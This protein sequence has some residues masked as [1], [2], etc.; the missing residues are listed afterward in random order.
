MPVYMLDW[1]S[2]SW[3]NTRSVHSRTAG[4]AADRI[5]TAS[6]LCVLE[7]M[8]SASPPRLALYRSLHRF[9]YYTRS[10]PPINLML[11]CRVSIALCVRARA[12]SSRPLSPSS[13]FHR[14]LSLFIGVN[15]IHVRCLVV[16]II[17]S[18]SSNQSVVSDVYENAGSNTIGLYLPL[19][20]S[21]SL[22]LSPSLSVPLSSSSPLHRS[23]YY[24]YENAC[25][26]TICLYLPLSPF[27]S[28]SL[29]ASDTFA[30]PAL[31][32][33]IPFDRVYNY[34]SYV[35]SFLWFPMTYASYLQS[36]VLLLLLHVAA[37]GQRLYLL[38]IGTS[39]YIYY[40]L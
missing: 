3:S 19:P 16:C 30:R 39:S 31:V 6:I 28:I 18:P 24:L 10:S 9:N 27:L 17:Y 37:G 11:N 21:L 35:G 7:A 26:Y 4:R 25:G 2:M 13:F 36:A 5:P 29:S 22:S 20:S 15:I 12:C 33:S 14:S 40:L 34:N 38:F 23:G 1:Y 8:F 32:A